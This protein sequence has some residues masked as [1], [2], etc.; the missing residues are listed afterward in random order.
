M[1]FTV[2]VKNPLSVN[3][4]GKKSLDKRHR[5]TDND[6]MS[7]EMITAG[8]GLPSIS[9][10]GITIEPGMEVTYFDMAN[11][12]GP[13]LTVLGPDVQAGWTVMDNTTGVISTRSI[14]GFGWTVVS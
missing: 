4:G 11:Q 5:M 1:I 9:A 8:N 13:V 14:R 6:H 2:G 12:N 3:T 7:T 10:N